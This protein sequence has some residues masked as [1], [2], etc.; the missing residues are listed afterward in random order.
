MGPANELPSGHG[1]VFGLFEGR[2]PDLDPVHA[3]CRRLC[4]STI[5]VGELYTWARRANASPKRLANLQALLAELTVLPVDLTVAEKF[6]EVR[7][8][9]LERGRTL[10][11]NGSDDRRG[12][13]RPRSDIGHT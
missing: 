10:P 5:T 9:L 7:A 11:R 2:S 8:A 12:R 1:Y 13:T 6:G 3:V 4:A